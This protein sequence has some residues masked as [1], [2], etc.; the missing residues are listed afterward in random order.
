MSNWPEPASFHDPLP[1]TMKECKI[2]QTVTPHEI[3]CGPGVAAVICMRCL[4]RAL[5]YELQRD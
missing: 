5:A 2:C 1:R 3:R 4:D